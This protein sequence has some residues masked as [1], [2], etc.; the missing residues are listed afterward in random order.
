MSFSP[1]FI[2]LVSDSL[3]LL[4]YPRTLLSLPYAF[5]LEFTFSFL[6]LHRLFS[7]LLVHFLSFI[8]LLDP[9][10]IQPE[11]LNFYQRLSVSVSKSS[12]FVRFFVLKLLRFSLKMVL[13]Q[14]WY[15]CGLMDLMLLAYL[16][17]NLG[18]FKFSQKDN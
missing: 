10:R 1:L 14:K 6:R 17:F 4:A 7:F 12:F 13:N 2:P 5:L 16:K 15:Y 9:S 18:K 3:S 11:V 8:F